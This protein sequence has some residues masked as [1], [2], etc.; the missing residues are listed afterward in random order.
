M[1]RI[2]S[3]RKY[4]DSLESLK[5]R[6]VAAEWEM[7]DAPTGHKRQS[8]AGTSPRTLDPQDPP[9]AEPLPRRRS[10]RLARKTRTMDLND[11]DSEDGSAVE[12][13]DQPPTGGSRAF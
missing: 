8:K 1:W 7:D 13:I 10:E 3:A 2:G 12:D 11:S 5:Q 6:V 4:A 9:D